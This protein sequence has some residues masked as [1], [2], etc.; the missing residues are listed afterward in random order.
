MPVDIVDRLR[1]AGCVYAEDEAAL[2]V[3]AAGDADELGLLVGRRAGGEPLEHILGWV[4]FSGLR[5]IVEPGV[6]VPRRRTEILVREAGRL[7]GPGATIVDLCCGSGAIGAA[8]VDTC[9]GI[10]LH[11]ADMDPAAVRNARLNLEPEGVVHQGDLFSAL[12]AELKGRVD[13]VVVNAPYVPKDA[14]ALMPPEAR[15]HESHMALDGGA[16]G[17]EVHRRIAAEVGEWLVSDGYV[18]IET[19]LVQAPLTTEGLEAAGFSAWT[20]RDDEIDGTAVI[21][22]RLV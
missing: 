11:A 3:D 7:A 22:T 9:Q 10:E 18:V 13:I 15:E 4:E 2:L 16:D 5:I 14:I 21:G 6:F 19:S 12:P 8:L 1:A 17:V 20:E